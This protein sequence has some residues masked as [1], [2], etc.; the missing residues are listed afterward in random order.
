MEKFDLHGST[1]S[2]NA[3]ACRTAMATL[4]ILQEEG[5][6]EASRVKGER[7]LGSL[8]ERLAGHPLVRD[9]RG[10]GLFVGIEL[11]PTEEPF[12]LD[13]GDYV[14]FPGWREHRYRPLDP[15]VR[16]LML[17]SYARSVPAVPVLQHLS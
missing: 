10:R 8:R 16:L 14:C 7:L 1:F 2:G 13:R 9:V 11:G 4:A 15:P 3:F 12:E 6:V 5:L 17:L